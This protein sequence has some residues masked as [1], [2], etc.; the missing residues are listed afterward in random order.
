MARCDDCW[1]LEAARVAGSYLAN[2]L[3]DVLEESVS[4]SPV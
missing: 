3:Q 1:S 4:K 2:R